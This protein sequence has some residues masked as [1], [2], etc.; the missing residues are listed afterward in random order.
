MSH[1]VR[2]RGLKRFHLQRWRLALPVAPRAGAWIETKRLEEQVASCY[3]SHPVRVRGLKHV[4]TLNSEGIKL[5]APRAGAR[6][7]TMLP[8]C[9][10]SH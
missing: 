5:V 2:V 7:E 4:F 9:K 6:I 10:L 1:P 3:M 8:N